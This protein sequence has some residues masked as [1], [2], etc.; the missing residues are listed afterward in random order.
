MNLNKLGV[1]AG[2]SSRLGVTGASVEQ[3]PT[4]KVLLCQAEKGKPPS[5]VLA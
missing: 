4:R 2:R 3:K 5:E 1:A